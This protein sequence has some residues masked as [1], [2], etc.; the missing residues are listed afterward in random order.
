MFSVPP[1][2]YATAGPTFGDVLACVSLIFAYPS[3]S[4]AHV[5]TSVTVIPTAALLISLM[6][7]VSVPLLLTL[8]LVAFGG[9]GIIR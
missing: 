7:K 4:P 9:A 6:L 8:T 3:L 2:W 5:A 1:F